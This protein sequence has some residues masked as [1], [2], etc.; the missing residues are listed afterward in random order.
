MNVTGAPHLSLPSLASMV[1][2]LGGVDRSFDTY[3]NNGVQMINLR[4]AVPLLP[5][6]KENWRPIGV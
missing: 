4:N 2:Q 1:G 5:V 3:R 6:L